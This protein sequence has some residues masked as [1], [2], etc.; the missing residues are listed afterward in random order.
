MMHRRQQEA[1]WLW[2]A[3]ICMVTV[4]FTVLFGCRGTPAATGKPVKGAVTYNG[5][6]VSGATVSFVS[7]SGASGFGMTNE[8]GQFTLRTAHGEGVPPGTYQVTIAKAETPAVEN[9]VSD[10]DPSYVPPDPDAM[11]PA[12]KDLLPI[13]YKTTATSGLTATVTDSGPNEFTFPLTD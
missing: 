10:Q 7:A 3:S 11:P 5:S 8:Q 12:P 13:K 9:S 6:P 4:P 2:L 1:P